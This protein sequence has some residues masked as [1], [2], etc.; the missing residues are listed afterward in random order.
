MCIR[1][2]SPPEAN[3]NSYLER[4][5]KV[6]WSRLSSTA[7][8]TPARALWS[9]NLALL[10]SPWGISKLKEALDTPDLEIDQ[11]RRWDLIVRLSQLGDNDSLARIES[12]SKR[13]LSSRGQERK[14]SASAAFPNWES[15]MLWL[16]HY[17][18]KSTSYSF[19]QLRSAIFSL[20]PSNQAKMRQQFARDFEKQ[21][22]WVNE[23]RNG[24]EAELITAIAPFDCQPNGEPLLT[25]IVDSNPKLQPILKKNL[26]QTAAEA[27]RCRRITSF[28][29][30][31]IKSNHP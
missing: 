22:N 25:A 6:I 29:I 7:K 24:Y 2:S 31:N 9:Q 5:D 16:E 23:N 17:K 13:D 12:E 26:I 20:F 28:Q 18:N 14:I 8:G 4:V 30:E 27:D 21:L 3:S 15:K 11:D 1:D 10:S 19:S